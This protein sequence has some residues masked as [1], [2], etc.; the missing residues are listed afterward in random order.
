MYLG[1]KKQ[2]FVCEIKKTDG[3]WTD[4]LRVKKQKDWEHIFNSE[5]VPVYEKL[6]GKRKKLGKYLV[7]N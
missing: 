1:C 3:T 7:S 4:R 6:G 2:F 5:I